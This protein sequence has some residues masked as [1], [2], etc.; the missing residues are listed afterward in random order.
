MSTVRYSP[1]TRDELNSECVP[2]RQ[3]STLGML[4]GPHLRNKYFN[5]AKY[6]KTSGRKT[7]R[8][9]F[10]HNSASKDDARHLLSRNDIQDDEDH[11]VVWEQNDRNTETPSE[12]WEQDPLSS[13]SHELQEASRLESQ[14]SSSQPNVKRVKASSKDHG[15]AGTD[16]QAEFERIFSPVRHSPKF[17]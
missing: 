15:I 13:E 10:S 6:S 11:E 8:D 7:I 1:A 16:L 2:L 12:L 9:M 4:S 14:P 3:P 5:F 17:L